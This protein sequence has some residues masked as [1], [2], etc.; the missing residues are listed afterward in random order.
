VGWFDVQRTAE[1]RHDPVFSGLPER[2]RA[3]QWHY[4]TYDLPPGAS[5]LARS[6]RCTQAFRLGENAWGIQFH[7]E[8]T[9]AQVEDWLANEVEPEDREHLPDDLLEETRREIGAWNEL[10]RELCGGFVEA[11]ERVG[12]AA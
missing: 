7:A 12:V 9:Q 11:A 4:Y 5:E 6:E 2:F 3:F 1:A 8:V 10:G